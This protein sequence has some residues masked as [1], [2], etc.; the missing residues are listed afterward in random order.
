MQLSLVIPLL[1][2]EESLRELH[3]WIDRV[4]KEHGIEREILFIDD[5]STD[6]SWD[7]IQELAD[8]DPQT[9]GHPFS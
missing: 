2:E 5:G 7:V 3:E 8:K 4:T 1:N 6:A 9:K